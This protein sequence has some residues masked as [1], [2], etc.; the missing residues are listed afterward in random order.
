MSTQDPGREVNPQAAA[1]VTPPAAQLEMASV[2]FMDIVSYSL[3]PMERQSSLLH[4]LQQIVRGTAEFQEAQLAN[5]LISLPTGDGMALV[6][7]TNTTIPVNCAIND[8]KEVTK[9]PNLKLRIG[10]HTG[11]VYRIADINASMN[12]AGGGINLAQRVMD[13]GDAGHVLLS[14][15]VAEVLKHL[16]G[17][18]QYLKDLGEH[19]VKHNVKMHLYALCTSDVPNH[20][21]PTKL[22]AKVQVPEP[23]VRTAAPPPAAAAADRSPSRGLYMAVGS[24]TTIL[25]IGFAAV[26]GPSFFDSGQAASRPFQARPPITFEGDQKPQSQLKSV[27]PSQE[28]SRPSSPLERIV[29]TPGR[30]TTAS[31]PTPAAVTTDPQPVPQPTTRAAIT[32]PPPSAAQQAAQTAPVETMSEEVKAARELLIN[33]TSR[34]TAVQASLTSMKQQQ[35]SMGMNLRGDIVS[36]QQRMDINLADAQAALRSGDAARAKTSLQTA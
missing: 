36:A 12:V 30:G 11:P 32:V 18:P 16:S 28:I 26:K 5:H 13:A 25:V 6:F 35:A 15:A 19:A 7:F 33:L 8:C 2:L 20:E 3:E 9:N 23:E 24:V 34:A 22:K 27:T 21:V 29:P 1:G 31:V 14:S 17:W 10:V 4:D